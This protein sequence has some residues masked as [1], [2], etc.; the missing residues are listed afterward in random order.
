M[1]ISRVP[2]EKHKNN[3]YI[4]YTNTI[5]SRRLTYH[6]SENN[7]IAQHLIIKHNNCTNFHFRYKEDSHG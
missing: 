1:S 5:L 2:P 3:I 6:L 4:G 7:A